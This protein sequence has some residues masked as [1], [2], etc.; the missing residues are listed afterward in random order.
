MRAFAQIDVFSPE[1]ARGNPV[2]VVLDATGLDDAT[3]QRLANWTNLSET[4]FVVPSAETSADYRIRIFTPSGELPFAGHPT[5]GA[6]HAWMQSNGTQDRAQVIQECAAGLIEVRRVDGRL[7]FAAPP[8]LRS[9]PLD[10][11]TLTNILTQLSLEEDEVLDHAWVDNGPGW[12]AVAI[13]D[14]ARLLSLI[15]A[16]PVTHR[17]GVV[18]L[19]ADGS[20]ESSRR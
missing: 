14:V 1:L 7:A 5:L 11:Q 17:T 12:T 4:A 18:A 10:D 3:M 13:R 2:L 20:P 8:L 19:H 15:A 6:A 9:G 16:G